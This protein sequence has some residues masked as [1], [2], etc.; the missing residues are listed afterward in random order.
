MWSTSCSFPAVALGVELPE[1]S[2]P[3]V[4]VLIV[5]LSLLGNVCSGVL[6]WIV[7]FDSSPFTSFILFVFYFF[8]K[9]YFSEK[10]KKKVEERVG[11]GF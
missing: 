8:L 6:K 3:L 9:Y 11:E 10:E 2:I 7:G 4:P 1:V 5:H